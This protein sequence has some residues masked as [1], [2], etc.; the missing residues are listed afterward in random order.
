MTE[1]WD[2]TVGVGSVAATGVSVDRA[3][4]DACDTCREEQEC[5]VCGTCTACA[6]DCA[7]CVESVSFVVPDLAPGTYGVV[8][9][10]LHAASVAVDLT[11]TSPDTGGTDTGDTGAGDSGDTGAADSGDTAEP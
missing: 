1:S 2:T 8:V 10:N 3:E 7:S 11:V 4:C 6:D 9:T 5:N